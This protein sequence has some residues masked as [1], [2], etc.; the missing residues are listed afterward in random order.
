MHDDFRRGTWERREPNSP[1]CSRLGLASLGTRQLELIRWTDW[2]F[3]V[4]YDVHITRADSWVDAETLPITL[5]EWLAYARSDPEMR[6]DG[7]A[8][9]R[10]TDGETIALDSAGLAVWT[11]YSKDGEDGNHAW[12]DLQDGRLIVKNPDTEI[13]C[14]MSRIAVHFHA[15]VQGDDGED[16]GSD[17]EPFGGSPNRA[18]WRRFLGR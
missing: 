8:E 13:L 5:D 16:Y 14:K 6:M 17:G 12:F 2:A 9:A 11:A 18:W 1:A 4:G 3:A 15:R 10:T 7:R